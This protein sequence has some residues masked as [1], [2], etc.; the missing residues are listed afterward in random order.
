MEIIILKI[1]GTAVLS[2]LVS[3]GVAGFVGVS[4]SSSWLKA[5]ILI[6]LSLSIVT[7]IAGILAIIWL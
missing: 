5:S 3:L 6:I 1:M 7:I 4:C 2:I